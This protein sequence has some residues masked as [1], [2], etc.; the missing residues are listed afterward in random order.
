MHAGFLDI[1]SAA[2]SI[3]KIATEYDIHGRVEVAAFQMGGTP[4]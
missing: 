2:A 4:S 1:F 3:E